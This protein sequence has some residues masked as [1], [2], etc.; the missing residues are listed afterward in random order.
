[1]FVFVFCGGG[2]EGLICV[3]VCRLDW[4]GLDGDGIMGRTDF[5]DSLF[6]S[7]VWIAQ[8]RFFRVVFCIIAESMEVTGW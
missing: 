4:T 2:E 6:P 1:M 7:G 8:H 5:G 3:C